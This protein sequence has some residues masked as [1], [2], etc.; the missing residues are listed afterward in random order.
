MQNLDDPS[1]VFIHAK[2][3][4]RN[5]FLKN[6]YIDFYEQLKGPLKDLPVTA[7]IVELGSGGGFIKEVL[8]QV[9]TT[10]I[11]NSSPVDMH[12]S[13]QDMPFGDKTVDA[14][15]MLNVLHHIPDPKQF[16]SEINR[17]LKEGGKF[18]MIEPA[19]TIWGRFVYRNFHHEPFDVKAGWKLEGSGPLTDANGAL[20]WM[21]FIRDRKIFEGTFP[22]L[23]IKNID[24]HTAFCYLLSGGV[25]YRPLVPAGMYHFFKFLGRVLRPLRRWVGMFYT[26]ELQKA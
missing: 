1:T 14:F 17:C 18:V 2:I 6:L 16:F 11:V 15:V 21:I 5:R 24:H 3:I 10:D 4:K 26:I 8:P 20:P 13:G 19:N 7:T 22:K 9:M 23:K 12:F 25:S